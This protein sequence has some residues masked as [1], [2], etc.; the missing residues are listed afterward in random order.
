MKDIDQKLEKITCL[1]DQFFGFADDNEVKNMVKHGS[2][3]L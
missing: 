1:Q 3:N 2:C